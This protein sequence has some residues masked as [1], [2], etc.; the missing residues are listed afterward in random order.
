[1]ARKDKSFYEAVQKTDENLEERTDEI[2]NMLKNHTYKVGLYKTS[3]YIDKGKERILYKLPYYPDRII[4][5]AIMLNIEKYFNKIFTP[6]V[7]A[8]LPQ[9]GIHYASKLLDHYLQDYPDKTTYYL[10][11]DIKKFYPSIN[12]NILKQLLRKPFKDKDL[13]IELD[14]I[15]DSFDKT[16][17]Y[18]LNLTD[19]EKAIYCRPGYGVPVGSYLSQYLA[20]FYLSYF[21]HWLIEEC[22]CGFIVRYMDDILILSNSKEFLHNLLCAIKIYLKEKLDLEI[23]N[24]YE[25]KPTYL[26]IDI[27]GYRYFYSYKLLRNKTKKHFKEILLESLYQIKNGLNLTEKNYNACISIA[28]WLCWANTYNF[29][30]KYFYPLF[31]YMGV[32]YFFYKQ[33]PKKKINH[34][35]NIQLKYENKYKL[36][37][38]YRICQSHL[39][40]H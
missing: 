34:T 25:I 23:K 20:N 36:N 7:C 16:D 12:R 22:G 15:I 24:N 31:P 8:S 11:F 39:A 26:G 3:R 2:S 13:L 6:F 14:K 38:C 10:K 17:V 33:S 37:K 19:K 27:V 28:G 18:K 35:L 21:D 30:K 32:Y 4:Q 40:I 5:W 9:R 29:Y 1:M